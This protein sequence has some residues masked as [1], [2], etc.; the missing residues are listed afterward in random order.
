MKVRALALALACT[1]CGSDIAS[2]AAKNQSVWDAHK[3]ARYRFDYQEDGEAVPAHLTITV[4]NDA[5]VDTTGTSAGGTSVKGAGMTLDALFSQ[6][7]SG[8]KSA[9]FDPSLGYPTSA[10]F[11]NG[12]EGWGFSVSHVVLNAP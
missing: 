3:T 9:T 7:R 12:Q 6:V 11:S 10:Q 5:V 1:A 4:D 8:A 2:E